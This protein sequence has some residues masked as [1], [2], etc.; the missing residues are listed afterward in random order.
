MSASG[1]FE[2][3]RRKKASK[4]SKPDAHKRMSDE[5]LLAHIRAI[6]AEVKGEYGC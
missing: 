6:H 1:Y 5:T 3:G 2:H 4:P